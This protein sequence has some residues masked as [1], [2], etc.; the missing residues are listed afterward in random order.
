MEIKLS[1]VE[2]DVQ[3][4]LHSLYEWLLDDHDIRSGS[5]VTPVAAAPVS[6]DMAGEL[7]LISLVV[8]SGFNIA[9]LVVAV[10]NWRS[11]RTK[12][13]PV[14]IEIDGVKITVE[15]DEP[16]TVERAKKLLAEMSSIRE[17]RLES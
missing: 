12:P 16:E 5:S 9:G 17:N 14:C 6:G 10:A 8:S 2:D 7:E 13:R 1:I 4:S 15:N 3:E 11:T